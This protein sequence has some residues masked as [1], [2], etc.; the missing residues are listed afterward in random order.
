MGEFEDMPVESFAPALLKG[1][2]WYEGRGV[3]KNPK[4]EDVKVFE[5]KGKRGR[6]GI[7][8]VN[9]MPPVFA[10]KDRKQRAANLEKWTVSNKD[11][12]ETKDSMGSRDHKRD[13]ACYDKKTSSKRGW[14]RYETS[15][16][17]SNSKSWLNSHIRDPKRDARYDEET[18]SKMGRERHETSG[19]TMCDIRM[20]NGKEL[21]Q[22]VD[23]EFLETALP[24][25]GGPVLVLCGRYK[26]V[27][28][29]LWEKDMDKETAV[30]RD[31][32]THA[33]VNVKFEQ[34]AE[35][36]GVCNDMRY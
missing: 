14:K 28:R 8:F 16:S 6:G 26:G 1:Y 20:D 29:S 12:K 25:R 4:E 34:I 32:A 21:I 3:G 23:E 35:Y 36:V 5:I 27:F 30:V 19:R 33:L 9:I 13:H 11:I 7:G 10:G 31:V 2:G 24:G 18:S 17:L 15:G 22:A